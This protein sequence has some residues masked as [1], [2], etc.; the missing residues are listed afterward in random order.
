MYLISRPSRLVRAAG[1]S[2][3][4]RRSELVALGLEHV[5]WTRNGMMLMIDPPR[6][7]GRRFD[8]MG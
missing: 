1:L 7:G 8:A 6:Q 4:L 5:T 2:G 3:A